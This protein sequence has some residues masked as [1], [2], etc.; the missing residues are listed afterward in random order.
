MVTSKYGSIY[1]YLGILAPA[2]ARTKCLLSATNKAVHPT[3]EYFQQKFSD[4]EKP[5]MEVKSRVPHDSKTTRTKKIGW[6]SAEKFNFEFFPQD[7]F[8][9]HS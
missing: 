6:E 9:E 2:L 4:P 5:S 1:D 8:M 3:P 7:F